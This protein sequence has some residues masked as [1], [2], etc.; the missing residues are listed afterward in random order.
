MARWSDLARQLA[1]ERYA[2]LLAYANMLTAGDHAAAEDITHDAFIRTFGRGRRL[3]SLAH[4]EYSVKRAILSAF[5][6]EARS[7][8]RREAL[9]ARV[10]TPYVAPSPEDAVGGVDALR[11]LLAQLTPQ[12]RACAVLRY[13]DDLTVET[14][15]SRLN[16]APGTVKRYL[17]NASARLGAALE[18]DPDTEHSPRVSVIDHGDALRKEH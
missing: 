6:D 2:A 14:M 18:I 16:L 9:A 17:S 1:D 12:E 10:A 8:K 3:T 15:A 13:V 4:A 7:R 11:R 5:L